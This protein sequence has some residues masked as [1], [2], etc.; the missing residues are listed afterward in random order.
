MDAI[1]LSFYASLLKKNYEDTID[2]TSAY[3]SVIGYR[4][5]PLTKYRNKSNIDFSKDVFEIIRT[6]N[7][8]VL[9]CM[10]IKDFFGN[11][12]HFNLYNSVMRFGKDIPEDNLR[13]IIKC[14][15]CAEVDGF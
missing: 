15:R 1:F 6:T 10:D 2:G 4:R 13:L 3:E 8:S 14:V 5:I 7:D 11:I 9:F 12:E